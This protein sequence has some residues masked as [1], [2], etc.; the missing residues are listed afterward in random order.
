MS[1]TQDSCNSILKCLPGHESDTEYARTR[2][3]IPVKLEKGFISE[4]NQ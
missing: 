3:K 4:M 1:G 2:K